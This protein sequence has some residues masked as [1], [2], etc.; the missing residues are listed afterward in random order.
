MNADAI[1]CSECFRNYGLKFDAY[2]LGVE[3]SDE[4]PNCGETAGRKLAAETLTTLAFRFFVWGSLQRQQYGAAPVLQFNFARKSDVEMLPWL[5][6]DI[7]LFERKLGIGFFYYGPRLWMIG[8]VEPLNALQDA[9]RMNVV[10]DQILNGYPT[11]NVRPGE[12]FYRLRKSPEKPDRLRDYDSPPIGI[13]GSGRLDSPNLSVMYASPDV[14]IC[15]HECRTTAEDEAYI[16]TLTPRIA[17]RLLDL[18]VL[19]TEPNVLEFESLDLAVLMLFLAGPHSYPVSRAISLA[20]HKGGFDGIVYPSYFSLLRSGAMPFETHYGISL[21]R[22]PQLH[23]SEQ[24]KVF[25]NL[26][27][28]GRPIQDG[29]VDVQCINKLVLRSVSY[30]FHFGPVGFD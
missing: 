15:I 24:S 26:A 20:A 6:T 18:T 22:Y 2:Q 11:R 9:T 23:E 1:V 27:I 10:I 14:Q 29:T 30:E 21:R 12:L 4:C 8:E 13:S 25:S 7:A 16:A 3:S 28:F 19:L 17:L 5:Q